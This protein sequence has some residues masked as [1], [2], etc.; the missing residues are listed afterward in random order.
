MS[1]I[2]ELPR[3]MKQGTLV[4]KLYAATDVSAINEETEPA[5]ENVAAV[6]IPEFLLPLPKDATNNLSESEAAKVIDFIQC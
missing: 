3:T 1:N 4:A 2:G 5:G 6:S